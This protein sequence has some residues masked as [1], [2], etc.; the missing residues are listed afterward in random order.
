MAAKKKSAPTKKHAAK[1]AAKKAVKRKRSPI[2]K[3]A[4]MIKND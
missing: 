1:K 4:P 2:K 3:A